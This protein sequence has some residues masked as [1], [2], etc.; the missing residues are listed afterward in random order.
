MMTGA[1][2]AWQQLNPGMFDETAGTVGHH[3]KDVAAFVSHV[4]Y[5]DL[6]EAVVLDTKRLIVDTIACALTGREAA[7][8]RITQEVAEYVGGGAQASVLGTREKTSAPLAAMVNAKMANA[9]DQDD[10]FMNIAHFAPQATMAPL[11]L[12]ESLHRSGREYITAVAC[13]YE[14]AARIALAANFW[15]VTSQL[16]FGGGGQRLVFGSN[17]FGASAASAKMLGLDEERIASAFGVCGYFAP[18]MIRSTESALEP[19]R[20]ADSGYMAKYC[21][22]GWSTFTGVMSAVYSKAGY[23]ANHHSLD[24][25][26]GYLRVMGGEGVNEDMLMHGLSRGQEHWYI[27]DSAFKTYPFCKY[28]H[29]PLQLFLAIVRENGLRV[30]DIEKVVVHL[31]PSHAL[32]FADQN[33]RN[34]HGIPC[35]HNIPYNLAMGAFGKPAT[36]EWHAQEN[37]SDPRVRAFMQ[38]VFT[39]PSGKAPQTGVEDIRACGFPKRIFSQVDVTCGGKTFSKSADKVK[40]DPWWEETRFTEQ[41][42]FDKLAGCAAGTLSEKQVEAAWE[43]IMNLENVTDVSEVTRLLRP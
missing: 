30:E 26:Y 42:C 11:A 32:G 12:G 18:V 10:C 29:T 5:E 24:G 34:S 19:P 3:T 41:D 13:G 39:Q 33:V 25:R 2:D 22:A 38:K 37:S 35:T 40:G 31:R 17:V 23:V 16:V 9:L 14:V 1:D 28:V 8:A 20:Y 27:S 43:G 6:P 7:S 4:A 15:K 21:D 36:H